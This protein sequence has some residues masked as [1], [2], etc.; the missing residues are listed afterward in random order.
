M[1]NHYT[2]VS[3]QISAKTSGLVYNRATKLYTGNLTITNNGPALSGNIDVVLDG[4]INLGTSSVPGIGDA[5][6]QYSTTSPKIASKIATKPATGTGSSDPGLIGTVTLVNETGS[7]NGEP[8]IR[9]TGSGLAAGKSVTIPLSFSNPTNAKINF[10]PCNLSGIGPPE[11]SKTMNFLKIKLL[12]IAVIMFAA[13]SA[14]ASLSYNV[15]VDTTSLN[16]TDGYLYLQYTPIADA[17]ASTATVSSFVTDGTLGSQSL[18]VLNGAAVTGTLP[19]YRYLR[20]HQRH[21]RLQPRHPFRQQPQLQ[22]AP[23]LPSLRHRDVVRQQHFF[24]RAL[25]G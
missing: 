19:G 15:T 22:P 21:Q 14:F 24:T 4:I 8:M 13:S 1:L 23:R 10:Q 12:I 16:N 18:N 5:D 7:N 6:N 17:V 2:D 20:Q 3:S 25:R 11:K 9:A